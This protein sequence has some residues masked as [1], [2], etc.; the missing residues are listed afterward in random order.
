MYGLS[1]EPLIQRHLIVA[2]VIGFILGAAIAVASIEQPIEPGRV[3]FL[4]FTSSMIA[5]GILYYLY[6]YI[7]RI[8]PGLKV[9]IESFI[10]TLL[11]TLA[12]TAVV[13]DMLT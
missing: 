5:S 2:G 6:I 12:S 13:Y 10:A 8:R 3:G 9:L 7:G 1:G 11:M 4:I